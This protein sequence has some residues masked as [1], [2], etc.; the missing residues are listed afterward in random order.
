MTNYIW[1]KTILS[2]YNYLEKISDAIDNIVEKR[3]INSY[4]M[5]SVNFSINNTMA[6]ADKLIELGDRKVRLINLK[7]LCEKALEKC[8]P[9]HASILIEK[10]VDGGKAQEIAERYNL[11]LRTY[12]RRLN[13]AENEFSCNLSMMGYDDKKISQYLS[14]EKWIEEIYRRYSSQGQEIEIKNIERMAL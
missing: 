7:I 10:Y 1:T 14:T 9:K 11:S 4:H 6:V 8:Q 5:S 12:F 3:A 13:M 2:A